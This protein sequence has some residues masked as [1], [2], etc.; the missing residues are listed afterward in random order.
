MTPRPIHKWKTFWLGLIILAF[1]TWAW[2][3]GRDHQDYAAILLPTGTWCGINS[4]NGKATLIITT[5]KGFLR[6]GYISYGSGDSDLHA[7]WFPVPIRYIRDDST[8]ATQTYYGIAHWLLTFLFFLGWASFL[9][10][11]SRRL[12]HKEQRHSC[13]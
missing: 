7:R 9:L 13:H 8:F 2:A 3:R 5:Y 12:H 11:R 10:F 4:S 1:L 6:A